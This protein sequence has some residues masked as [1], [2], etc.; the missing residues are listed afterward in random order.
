MR[1]TRASNAV[2]RLKERSNNAA[3]SMVSLPDGRFYLALN[4]GQPNAEKVSEALEQDAFVAFVNSIAKQ[5]PKKLSK[6]D[7][8]FEQKLKASGKSSS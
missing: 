2:M 5:A 4:H 8:A 7:V 6:L 3:Y 1:S